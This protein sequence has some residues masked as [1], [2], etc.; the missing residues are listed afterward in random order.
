M[1]GKLLCLQYKYGNKNNLFSTYEDSLELVKQYPIVFSVIPQKFKDKALVMAF[2]QANKVWVDKYNAVVAQER[3]ADKQYAAKG[4][5]RSHP[6]GRFLEF[7]DNAFVDSGADL[8]TFLKDESVLIAVLDNDYPFGFTKD[9]YD[10]KTVVKVLKTHHKLM[11]YVYDY[12][13]DHI[14]E[15]PNVVEWLRV[16]YELYNMPDDLELAFFKCFSLTQPDN[17]KNIMQLFAALYDDLIVPMPTST[18]NAEIMANVLSLLDAETQNFVVSL[19]YSCVKFMKKG[20]LDRDLEQ[21]IV[22]ICPIAGDILSDEAILKYKLT[23]SDTDKDVCKK[24]E[25]CCHCTLSRAWFR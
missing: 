18:N 2:L 5:Y 13:K 11:W 22:N 12:W 15:C 16:K 3:E 7:T 10:E 8:G 19:F 23:Q 21:D 24:C 1:N 17:K 9:S 6:K 4:I 20:I 25:E 14:K